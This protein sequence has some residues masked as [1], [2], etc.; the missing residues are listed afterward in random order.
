MRRFEGAS[1]AAFAL[2]GFSWNALP[3][4]VVSL[5]R[6]VGQVENASPSQKVSDA[7]T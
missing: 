7:I 5:R 1:G 2:V 4:R 3:K 6:F